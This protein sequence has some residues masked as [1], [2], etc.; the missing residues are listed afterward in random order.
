MTTPIEFIRLHCLKSHPL[1]FGILPNSAG[2]RSINWL[3]GCEG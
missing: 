1:F 2:C 3:G